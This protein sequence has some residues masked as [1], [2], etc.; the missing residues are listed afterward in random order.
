MVECKKVIIAGIAA[1]IVMLIVSFGLMP[2]WDMIFPGLSAEY[3]DSGIFRPWDDPWMSY[4]FIQPFI[5]G[6]ILAFVFNEVHPF[7]KM[8]WIKR[9]LFYGFTFWALV[10]IPGML[11]TYSSFLVSANMVISWTIDGL[12]GLL[13]A[14]IVVAKLA[15]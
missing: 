12:I 7:K 5:M 8:E 6:M 15:E 1:G 10:T 11:V 2:V 4:I 14:G 9:G 3:T 13:L